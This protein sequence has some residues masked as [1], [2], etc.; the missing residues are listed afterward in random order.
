MFLPGQ[1][2]IIPLLSQ[3]IFFFLEFP[4]FMN[5]SAIK[6]GKFM[7]VPLLACL[8]AIIYRQRLQSGFLPVLF[9]PVLEMHGTTSLFLSSIVGAVV[10]GCNM[11]TTV[12][13]LYLSFFLLWLKI[14]MWLCELV[15]YPASL[16][17]LVVGCQYITKSFRNRV[18]LEINTIPAHIIW[19]SFT[20]LVLDNV[21]W[22]MI[23]SV[24]V[25]GFILTTL[26]AI[27]YLLPSFV[28]MLLFP[29]CFF[30]FVKFL[31]LI[32][33][34]MHRKRFFSW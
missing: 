7:L 10:S 15:L 20:L 1:P 17:S 14:S 22:V 11:D 2:N 25:W 27:C 24:L 13:Q 4:K 3:H 8:G 32:F 34:N 29:Q 18:Q 12:W 33:Q 19:G 6:I 23:R 5:K 21:V 31:E 26:P 16:C 30:V 28:W 9:S